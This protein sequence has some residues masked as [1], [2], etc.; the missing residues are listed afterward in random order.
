MSSRS[1]RPLII[2]HRGAP[3]YRPEH[4]ESSYRLACELGVDLVE[5]D[6]VVTSDGVLVVRHENE[7][8]GTTDVASKREFASRKTTKVVDG[9]KHTGWFTEDFTWAELQ[10]LRCT[11][12]LKAI[13]PDNRD[14]DGTEG[15]LRL[16]DVLRIIDEE[17]VALRRNIGVVV[18]VKH[19]DFFWRIGVDIAALLQG[20]LERFGWADRPERLVI[21]CFELGVLRRLR[22]AG[23]RASYVFLA[24]RL[25]APA[26]EVL[27]AKDGGESA[28]PYSWYRTNEGLDF[29]SREVDGVSVDKGSLIRTNAIGLA[30]GPSNL[31]ERAHERGLQVFTWT[32]RPENRFLNIRFHS[33]LRPSE[34]GD[35]QSEFDLVLASG[36]D[37][38]FVDH[39][40]LGVAARDSMATPKG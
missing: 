22:D 14:Y 13:R 7:I 19:A 21:E 1:P 39:P 23:V 10:T 5:P 2:G 17:S 31:A 40:D 15:I 35:W 8:S 16:R 33:S 36:V 20:E 26:D 4:S 18:E 37:G 25:G 32:L 12:R 34:W 27:R 3:G 24:E 30:A 9:K 6:I 38:I 29:L 11:E 28:K